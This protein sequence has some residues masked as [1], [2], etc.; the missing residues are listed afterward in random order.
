MKKRSTHL[1]A[2]ALFLLGTAVL[3]GS[4]NKTE[5]NKAQVRKVFEEGLT[6]GRWDVFEEVHRKD[7]IAHAGKRNATLAEDLNSAKGWRQAFPDL[8]MTVDQMVAEGDLV[9]VRFSGRGTN[10]GSGNG[11]PATGNYADGSGITIFRIM[12][13]QIA[14]EWTVSDELGLLR[15]LGLLPAPGQ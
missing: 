1:L 11:L 7:F 3:A 14:E 15:Q 10:T 5:R 6:Q 9:A 12:D 13:G 4:R 2:L 8:V